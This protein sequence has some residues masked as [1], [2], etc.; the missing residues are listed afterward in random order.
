MA[1]EMK[2]KDFESALRALEGIVADLEGGEL[3][4]DRALEL[5]EEGVRIT[6]F[7][8]NKLDQAERKVEVLLKNADG[9]V[10]EAPFSESSAPRDPDPDDDP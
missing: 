2:L 5:F 4:L 1:K 8:N 6:R 3:P 10:S 9:T 7:C